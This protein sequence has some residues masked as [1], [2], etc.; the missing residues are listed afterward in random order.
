MLSRAVTTDPSTGV[1]GFKPGRQDLAFEPINPVIRSANL[2]V[3][4]LLFYDLLEPRSISSVVQHAA[5][6]ESL[7]R[8][9]LCQPHSVHAT[10]ITIV[11]RF[12][13]AGCQLLMFRM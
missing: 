13:P 7:P 11:S 4:P 5:D 10:E 6:L 8:N 3:A 2:I 9:R 1:R 12:L